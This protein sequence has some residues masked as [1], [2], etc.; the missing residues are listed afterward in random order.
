MDANDKSLLVVT[1]RLHVEHSGGCRTLG[2]FKGADFLPIPS[3][4]VPHGSETRTLHKIRK[5]RGTRAIPHYGKVRR[6]FIKMSAL[7]CAVSLTR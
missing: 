6:F 1:V 4:R 2:A 3:L 7:C 5:E